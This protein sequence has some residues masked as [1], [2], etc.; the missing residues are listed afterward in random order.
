MSCRQP[1][2][3]FS[4]HSSSPG[5]ITLH[6]DP[7]AARAATTVPPAWQATSSPPS[8]PPAQPATGEELSGALWQS[9]ARHGVLR[10]FLR[11]R[12]IARTVAEVPLSEQERSDA[13]QAWS[14]QHGLTTPE[15]LQAHLISQGLSEPDL[16]W[17]AE[18]PLRIQRHAETHFGPQ[19][20][21]HFLGR[22]PELD[23]LTYSV[24]RVEEESLANEL[25][26][27]LVEEE[28]DFGELVARFGREP[29]RANLGRVGPLPVNQVDP[30][31]MDLLS[32]SQVGQLLGPLSIDTCWLVVR[33][34][35]FQPASFDEEA[36]RQRMNRELFDAWVE[37]EVDRLVRERRL[38]APVGDPPVAQTTA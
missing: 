1:L 18:L 8:Q 11:Q 25:Y 17:Q 14:E 22:R 33:L 4:T 6:I 32:S 35:S 10:T 2:P 13:H 28:A 31:L 36:T 23:R 27:R 3:V 30:R 19:A 37:E 15:A 21:S 7:G 26:L 34:E 24:L 16:H 20:E 9:L 38:P 5:N 29:E 12:L